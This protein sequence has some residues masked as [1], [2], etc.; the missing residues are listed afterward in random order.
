MLQNQVPTLYKT[1][2][3]QT[4]DDKTMMTKSEGNP[5][6]QQ[7]WNLFFTFSVFILLFFVG[8]ITITTVAPV[9]HGH[10]CNS[11]LA[12]LIMS[13]NFIFQDGMVIQH[14]FLMTYLKTCSEFY[15]VM[16]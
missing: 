11:N 5:L 13:L 10:E 8:V 6:L 12:L 15:I 14:T 4:F 1:K 2:F 16:D 7:M 3:L 9:D